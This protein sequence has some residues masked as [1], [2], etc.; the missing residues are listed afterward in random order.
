L[1]RGVIEYETNNFAAA[2]V[3]FQEI[4]AKHAAHPFRIHAA[5][6]LGWVALKEKKTPEARG[7]FLF[8]TTAKTTPALISDSHYQIALIA[9]ES[10]AFP[11]A[12]KHLEK[13]VAGGTVVEGGPEFDSVLYYAGYVQSQME[14]WPA[15][16]LSLARVLKE[17]P[18][19][20]R[21]ENALYELAWCEE[22]QERPAEAV[23]HYT[24]LLAKFPDSALAGSSAVKLAELQYA[25]GD[26][27]AALGVLA[28]W[29]GK[30]NTQDPALAARASFR[31]G[32]C[33]LKKEAFL[34]AA[35]SFESVLGNSQAEESI[36]PASAYQAAEARLLLKEYPAAAA[37]Y[38]R[39]AK[40]AGAGDDIRE[41]ATLR[42][43]ECFGLMSRWPDSERVFREFVQHF[44]QSQFLRRSQLGLGWAL[45]NQKRFPEA[46]GE[47]QKA[48]GDG[49]KEKPKDET[50]ARSQFQIGECWLAQKDFDRAIGEFVKVE[51]HYGFPQWSSKS[52]LEIGNAFTAKGDK[53]SASERFE[54]VIKRYPGSDAATVAK[55]FLEQNK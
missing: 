24:E 21:L 27:D 52:L 47:Y 16:V 33:Q 30:L 36:V 1:E 38:D 12:R 9:I 29:I 22:M 41:Q 4:I 13:L 48:S 55:Q 39:A 10:Q 19:S 34:E 44:P 53:A 40:A 7:H 25:A 51:L 3:S 37:H 11:E 20:P 23:K 45:E 18:K 8:V 2:R 54:E 42:L 31:L 49:A 28:K 15:A 6:R 14:D 46:I 43:G 26:F 32:W 5:Y 50:A 35:K 17:F